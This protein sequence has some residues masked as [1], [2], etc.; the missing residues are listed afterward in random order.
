MLWHCWLAYRN[1]IPAVRKVL[2]EIHSGPG[3]TWSDLHFNGHFPGGP[4]LAGTRMS[5]FWTLLKLRMMVIDI[6]HTA[7]LSPPTNQDPAFYS[8]CLSWRPTN[9][10]RALKVNI[11]KDTQVLVVCS[12]CIHN[13]ATLVFLTGKKDSCSIFTC[14]ITSFGFCSTDHFTRR[15]LQVS[16]QRLPKITPALGQLV[17][18][19]LPACLAI[20]PTVWDLISQKIN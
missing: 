13:G 1:L 5:P 9:S 7:I 12:P 17:W 14:T 18:D 19:F 3:L 15:L 20:Q 8:L 11:P 16:P 2:W 6:R 10:V 4:G